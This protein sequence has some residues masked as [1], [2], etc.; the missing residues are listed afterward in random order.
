[1]GF[2]RTPSTFHFFFFFFCVTAHQTPSLITSVSRSYSV[3]CLFLC[4]RNKL[5]AHL[6]SLYFQVL[7]QSICLFSPIE[8]FLSA[9]ILLLSSLS[10]A[11]T[12][13]V[14]HSR[15]LFVFPLTFKSVLILTGLATG[16][17]AKCFV[18]SGVEHLTILRFPFH[19]T[20]RWLDKRSG[21]PGKMETCLDN[22]FNI[23]CCS[24]LF[25]FFFLYTAGSH[26]EF[27]LS[28]D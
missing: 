13:P 8:L 28:C 22:S 14:C 15:S 10:A 21:T 6:L 16:C 25:F 11:S 24:I 19:W 18:G 23:S 12:L 2:W 1:M 17:S 7:S 20:S 27:R 9:S 4:R 5:T 26:Q 3:F